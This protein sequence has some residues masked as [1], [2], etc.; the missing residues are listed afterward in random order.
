MALVGKEAS[1][2]GRSGNLT[3]PGRLLLETEELIFRGSFLLRMRLSGIARVS[4]SGGL[5]TVQGPEGEAEFELGDRAGD[6]VRAIQNPKSVI[7]KLGAKPGM[8][9]RLLMADPDLERSLENRGCIPA[10]E[11]LDMLFLAADCRQDLEELSASR[12]LL[13]PAGMI[14]VVIP[15]GIRAFGVEQVIAAA[16]AADLVDVKICRY[17]DTHTAYKLVIPRALR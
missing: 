11:D 8:R 13:R 10:S 17:S 4:A 7:D 1:C 3:S 12:A 5:M 2:I 16:R 9:V 15:K 6:W 14:W